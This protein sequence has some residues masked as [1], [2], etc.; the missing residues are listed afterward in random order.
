MKTISKLALALMAMLMVACSRNQDI[1]MMTQINNDGQSCIRCFYFHTDSASLLSDADTI[2]NDYLRI[3]KEW[4][5]KWG[6]TDA[7]SVYHDLPMTSQQYAEIQ[8]DLERQGIDKRVE[9][10]VLVVA[11]RHYRTTEE[12]SA[13][14]PLMLADKPLT[15]TST[16]KKSFRWFYT[17]YHFSET[18]A[19]CDTIFSVP[20]TDYVD[21][22]MASYWFT[23]KPNLADGV[24]GAGMKET[25][26]DVE[27]RM[28]QWLNANMFSEVY[29]Q[30][31]ERYDEVDNPPVSRERFSELRDSV[32]H[33]S[34]ISEIDFLN[35]ASQVADVLRNF[36][37]SDAYTPLLEGEEMEEAL[38]QRYAIYVALI[39][40]N[41]QYNLSMP[42]RFT[43]FD[44]E[45]LHFTGEY[46]VP[47]DYTITASSRVVHPWAFVATLLL[48][49]IPLFLFR[50]KRKEG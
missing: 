16:M 35:V 19:S 9:D 25:L 47:H 43:A 2:G 1:K 20:I 14:L 28:S 22:D 46:L 49:L 44:Y 15:A 13:D 29:K 21:K 32:I 45:P 26:D 24:P 6:F 33:S 34:D 17:D 27:Q 41:V 3:G 8:K 42:G 11:E 18:Y 31:I 4:K 10:T 36:F 40:F 48:I 38:G 12:M 5:R 39:G 30:I 37:H 50:K 7:D 23:G